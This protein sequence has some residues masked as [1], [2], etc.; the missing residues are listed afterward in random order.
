MIELLIPHEYVGSLHELDLDRLRGRG[1]RAL[2]V[3]LDNTLVPWNDGQPGPRALE[4]L[5]LVRD[6][7]MRVCIVSN[8]SAQRV[9]AFGR[10]LGVP[11]VAGA[12]KPRRQAFR[13]AMQL[14]GTNPSETAVVG[15]Q[16]FTDVLGGRRLG[17]YTVLVRPL[18]DREFFVTRL[19]RRLE[20][21]VL[22]R[23]IREGRIAAGRVPAE[24]ERP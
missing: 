13:R 24:R 20:R 23:L 12:A 10:A 7:G 5:A 18:S 8:N 2:I 3:D 16:L 4:W 19:V 15:D 22:D 14:L 11:V 1:V 6:R 21:L 9:E 17:L